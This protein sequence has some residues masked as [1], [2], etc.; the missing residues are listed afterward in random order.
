MVAIKGVDGYGAAH[1]VAI[2]SNGLITN[3]YWKCHMEAEAGWELPGFDDSHWA[4]AQTAANRISRTMGAD[5][6]WWWGDEF[7]E[8]L[9]NPNLCQANQAYCR[10]KGN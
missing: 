10:F 9:A 1:I 6:I 4:P 3:G 8:N 5:L 7:T 2:F